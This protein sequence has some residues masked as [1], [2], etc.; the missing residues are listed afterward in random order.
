[1]GVL[2]IPLLATNSICGGGACYIAVLYCLEVL[3]KTKMPTAEHIANIHFIRGWSANFTP[4][5]GTINLAGFS[6]IDREGEY[7]PRPVYQLFGLCIHGVIHFGRIRKYPPYT[8]IG[9]IRRL[10]TNLEGGTCPSRRKSLS[11]Y[12]SRHRRVLRTC[13]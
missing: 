8:Q 7:P 2:L 6:G 9:S 13:V 5:L 12:R 3:K 4:D 1:M 10:Q 11:P